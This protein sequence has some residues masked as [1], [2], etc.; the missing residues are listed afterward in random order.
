MSSHP[1]H[2]HLELE[3]R[4]AVDLDSHLLSDSIQDLPVFRT[5]NAP[6]N[7]LVSILPA[8]TPVRRTSDRLSSIFRPELHFATGGRPDTSQADQ[9]LSALP[10]LPILSEPPVLQ[11]CESLPDDC[12]FFGT[13]RTTS[14]FY[15][16]HVDIDH[17]KM[18][19]PVESLPL[20]TA[21]TDVA[22]GSRTTITDAEFTI[23]ISSPY[24]I[25]AILTRQQKRLICALLSEHSYCIVAPSAGVGGTLSI[26]TPRVS[27]YLLTRC[28]LAVGIQ[29]LQVYGYG[30]KSGWQRFYAWPYRALFAVP[31]TGRFDVARSF[32]HPD[33]IVFTRG[34]DTSPGWR[35]RLY[36]CFIGRYFHDQQPVGTLEARATGEVGILKVKLYS[37]FLHHIK[38]WTRVSWSE[39][40]KTGQAL[41]RRVKILEDLLV[42][43]EHA[44]IGGYR[45]ELTVT[46]LPMSDQLVRQLSLDFAR[47]V[48]GS[49]MQAVSIPRSRYL[50]A[51]RCV[52]A[53]VR[54]VKPLRGR[55]A[56]LTHKFSQFAYAEV[57][58]TFGIANDSIRKA[59][60]D[61]NFQNWRDLARRRRPDLKKLAAPDDEESTSDTESSTSAEQAR[62]LVLQHRSTGVQSSSDEENSESSVE[63]MPPQSRTVIAAIHTERS[64]LNG[65]PWLARRLDGR[66]FPPTNRKR[67][68]S[69][70]DLA[71]R[72]LTELPNWQEVLRLKEQLEESVLRG[73]VS[74]IAADSESETPVAQPKFA[75]MENLRSPS[76]WT[77]DGESDLCSRG[78]YPHELQ[79]SEDVDEPSRLDDDDGDQPVRSIPH[80]HSL[81]PNLRTEDA[82]LDRV[83]GE[84]NPLDLRLSEDVDEPSRLDDDGDQPVRSIPHRHSV[85]DDSTID[86]LAWRAIVIGVYESVIEWCSLFEN[87]STELLHRLYLRGARCFGTT[88]LP[89]SGLSGVAKVLGTYAKGQCLFA[90]CDI[91]RGTLIGCYLGDLIRD[92]SASRPQWTQVKARHQAFGRATDSVFHEFH[93][94]DDQK[95]RRVYCTLDANDAMQPRFGVFHFANAAT[96]PH[97]NMHVKKL[98]DAQEARYWI[99]FIASVDISV[100]DE[101]VWTY[102]STNSRASGIDSSEYVPPLKLSASVL[103]RLEPFSKVTAAALRHD[104]ETVTDSSVTVYKKTTVVPS[105][106]LRARGSYTL[107][108]VPFPNFGRNSCFLSVTMH[109]LQC[110]RVFTAVNIT[111]RSPSSLN[112]ISRAVVSLHSTLNKLVSKYVSGSSSAIQAKLFV[113]TIQKPLESQ[114]DSCLKVFSRSLPD[115]NLRGYFDAAELI[116]L[117]FEQMASWICTGTDK[118]GLRAVCRALVTCPHCNSCDTMMLNT[119]ITLIPQINQQNLEEEISRAL[120]EEYNL[121]GHC[122]QCRERHKFFALPH[123]PDSLLVVV[124]RN[125][126]GSLATISPRLSAVLDTT[127]LVTPTPG[128]GASIMGLQAVVFRY[129]SIHGAAHFTV[130][131]R[132]GFNTW[133]LFDDA[134]FVS[135]DVPF[136]V[137]VGYE[138]SKNGFPVALLYTH[139]TVSAHDG[140]S[141]GA[142]LPQASAFVDYSLFGDGDQD[143]TRASVVLETTVEL[144]SSMG[145]DHARAPTRVET[146]TTVEHDT[147]SDHD[148]DHTRAS[149][150]LETTV[151]L[152]SSMGGDHALARTRVETQTTMTR[153]SNNRGATSSTCSVRARASNF[154]SPTKPLNFT[155]TLVC[156]RKQ[157]ALF[158]LHAKIAERRL[159]DSALYTKHLSKFLPMKLTQLFKLT[160][161]KEM[162][163]WLERQCSDPTSLLYHVTVFN[164]TAQRFDI[165]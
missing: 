161:T 154:N 107:G 93:F 160:T 165:L 131:R 141:D 5:F 10:E 122:D 23:L 150:V 89:V 55:S 57:L 95:G 50:Q 80:R 118:S 63:D 85:I 133:A 40:P 24:V 120:R 92:E 71:L 27:I 12:E 130:F 31:T 83:T 136:E 3:T 60:N 135:A 2:H 157:A 162:I 81:N 128:V 94:E 139:G 129:G 7:D 35:R 72:V 90:R 126:D 105:Y 22:L 62:S 119:I 164:D 125:L 98:W 99:G 69:L 106:K 11:H 17:I 41:K 26:G 155:S 77:E 111:D 138:S 102:I 79:R 51:V 28:L 145:G 39:F 30:L 58:S 16:D 117:V 1:L 100:G 54:A 134:R 114:V 109:L 75:F 137:V 88:R 115:Y 53:D 146:Q 159:T 144:E 149:V 104:S 9:P 158:E 132:M 66:C 49:D 123:Y 15:D 153:H 142:A 61:Q 56:E 70:A 19:F 156:A 96:K 140:V 4:D 73:R 33:I 6:Y 59:H 91:A 84:S 14:V 13:D 45:L 127:H 110:A 48:F 147:A 47:E 101:L 8:V 143:H 25:R 108:F 74:S 163:R 86:H 46:G 103:D 148:Q 97:A 38:A 113:K 78:P 65:R 52:L 18:T 151:E 44:N 112:P 32:D 152:E 76:P 37:Q 34:S 82:G 36:Q 121:N 64:R 43:L 116:T 87:P 42:K 67:C 68:H 124:P 20:Y 29:Y 21:G